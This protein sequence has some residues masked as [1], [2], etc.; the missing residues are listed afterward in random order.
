MRS[1]T[2]VES[3]HDVSATLWH[4]LDVWR[5]TIHK[6]IG[7][8]QAL[9]GLSMCGTGL[10]AESWLDVS[11]A[12]TILAH[13]SSTNLSVLQTFQGLAAGAFPRPAALAE[14]HA[15]HLNLCEH[16]HS[17]FIG[18]PSAHAHQQEEEITNDALPAGSDYL[19]VAVGQTPSFVRGLREFA[20]LSHIE[21]FERK[22]PSESIETESLR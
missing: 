2:A 20:N 5:C 17:G 7:L 22:P 18:D 4:I 19:S 9:D 15:R 10:A 14:I 21:K 1:Q 11:C 3:I 8:Q 16:C 13:T 6:G 12:F